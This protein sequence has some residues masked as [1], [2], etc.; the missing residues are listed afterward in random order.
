MSPHDRAFAK[1]LATRVVEIDRGKLHNYSCGFDRYPERREERLAAEERAF[2][3]QDK[4]LAQEEVWIRQGIKAR[5][6]RNMENVDRDVVH[7]RE[8][9]QEASQAIEQ[10][11]SAIQS[12]A[13]NT[14]K[15]A[16]DAALAQQGAVSGAQ[17]V[18]SAV[19]SIDQV[20]ERILLLKETMTV[21]SPFSATMER[22]SF[23]RWAMSP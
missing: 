21:L 14:V 7:Q 17:G 11:N 5:R 6:T 8:R 3:L 9:M 23:S 22:L 15:A 4:K 2:A 19:L 16:D 20:K 18:R 13:L 1:R 12:I 10:I